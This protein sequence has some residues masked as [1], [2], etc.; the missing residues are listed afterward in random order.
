MLFKGSLQDILRKQGL[1]N[2][3][4]NL[5][6]HLETLCRAAPLAKNERMKIWTDRF[7]QLHPHEL[8]LIGVRANIVEPKNVLISEEN[9]SGLYRRSLIH[10]H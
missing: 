2:H 8:Y 10:C 4:P 9:H 1:H 6:C 3:E 5:C 7:K